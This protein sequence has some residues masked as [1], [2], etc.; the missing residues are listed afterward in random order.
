M[1]RSRL[2]SRLE[3]QVRQAQEKQIY[4]FHTPWA[5]GLLRA[6]EAQERHSCFFLASCALGPGWASTGKEQLLLPYPL[7]TKPRPWRPKR[8]K[9]REGTVAQ[10]EMACCNP[11]PFCYPP[12]PPGMTYTHTLL[13]TPPSHG[14]AYARTLPLCALPPS[15][16]I[17]ATRV[18]HSH[19]KSSRA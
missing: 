9:H 10:A 15:L 13:L 2:L 12:P 3:A 7:R 14:M 5:W 18:A 1:R 17:Q 11:T 8:G 6:R 16:C 4:F 19:T